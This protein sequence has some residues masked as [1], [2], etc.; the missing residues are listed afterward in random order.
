MKPFVL[1]A[2]GI[3]RL[4]P[5]VSVQKGS[6]RD[7]R[8]VDVHASGEFTRRRG[9]KAAIRDTGFHSLY[10]AKQ[11]GWLFV[12][13]NNALYRLHPDTNTL[14]FIWM[15]NSSEPLSYCE[16]NGNVYFVNYNSSGYL[17]SDDT[18]VWPLGEVMHTVPSISAASSGNFLPGAYTF[19]FVLRN[20]RGEHSGASRLVS[21]NLANPG[22]FAISNLPIMP[23]YEVEIYA[24]TRDGEELRLAASKPAI[25]SATELKQSEE[26]RLC[27]TAHLKPIHTG[28][29]IRWHNGRLY[30]AHND[31]VYFSEALRPHL[32]NSA[33]NFW[34]LSGTVSIVEP[35]ASGIY[36][37]DSRGVWFYDGPDPT[38]A[39]PKLV[40][41]H[42]AVFR[43][44]LRVDANQFNQKQ[45]QTSDY[46]AMWL[47][48]SGF[49]VGL[50]TG[51]ILEPN[52]DKVVLPHT[53]E[54][55]S[56]TLL[57]RGC[58]QVITL[59]G[60]S[61]AKVYNEAVN[62]PIVPSFGTS[63][64]VVSFTAHIS[65]SVGQF[66]VAS[67][68]A[69]EFSGEL[70]TQIGD[71]AVLATNNVVL[72]ALASSNEFGSL[73]LTN[74]APTMDTTLVTVDSTVT[75]TA[76]AEN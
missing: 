36:V 14:E 12:A 70:F 61:S 26:G 2:G 45:V 59:S 16:Y 41:H 52:A 22:G 46:C 49:V 3:D 76:D 71:I 24:T 25:Y 69:A 60:K 58:K 47:S 7:I 18:V 32:Y 44:S 33:H 15:L 5:E 35:V 65:L 75:F 73:V 50:A 62:Y 9:A 38:A 43:S 74:N 8:N 54:G 20:Q 64:A 13:K 37:G 4:S 40:T 72:P 63:T 30:V 68:H 31:K 53:L 57:N 11:R 27:P 23:G 29:I 42:R 67:A 56:Y 48:A 51:Q 17:P 19:A 6:F 28:D 34:Q 55:V 66:V 21:F 1:P 39:K 10:Y